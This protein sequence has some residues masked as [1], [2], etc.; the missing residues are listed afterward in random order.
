MSDQLTAEQIAAGE[1]GVP[2]FADTIHKLIDRVLPSHT[3]EGALA[4]ESVDQAYPEEAKAAAAAA[5]AAAPAAPVDARD[6]R[7]AQLEAQLAAQ[8]TPQPPSI[9]TSSDEA[10]AVAQS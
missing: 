3:W 5:A 10:P 8:N 7:I 9:V 2:T 6:A 4:H 1:H